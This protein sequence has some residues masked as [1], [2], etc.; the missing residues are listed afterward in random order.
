MPTTY[1][2]NWIY[3]GNFAELDTN[4]SNFAVEDADTLHGTTFSTANNPDMQFL[5]VTYT[6]PDGDNGFNTNN[7]GRTGDSVSYDTGTGPQ[8]SI[9]DAHWDYRAEVLHADG[10]TVTTEFLGMIQL[11]NGDLFINGDT[12]DNLQ[13]LSITPI[14]TTN[15]GYDAFYG[16]RNISNSSIVCFAAET[17]VA[18]PNGEVPI[19]Q[20]Q[21]GD[22]VLTAD[23]GAQRVTWIRRQVLSA[24]EVAAVPEYAPVRIRAGALGQGLPERDL[25]VS[26]QHRLLIRS[27]IAQR[28]F[29]ARE[30]LCAAKHLLAVPG[31]DVSEAGEAVEYVHILCAGHQIIFAEGAPTETLYLGSEALKTV[32]QDE[33]LREVSASPMEPAR[34][35]V[36]GRQTRKLAER[37][38]QNNKSLLAGEGH[39]GE[40][41]APHLHGVG[42][43]EGGGVRGEVAPSG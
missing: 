40:T 41:L 30:V 33:G 9:I 1:T 17:R 16:E 4:D 14:Q 42:A 24:Q 25:Y 22:H 29:D 11:E 20:L 39:I 7:V 43:Q 12:L 5:D 19:G 27:T 6:E 2:S 10:V 21:P 3:I 31:I 34:R 23:H 35:L 37:H 18:T 26:Q 38:V 36:N 8:S 13:I 32:G 28:M 15:S